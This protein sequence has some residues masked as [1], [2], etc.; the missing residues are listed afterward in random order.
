MADLTEYDR[1]LASAYRFVSYRPRSKKEFVDFCRKT[2]AR[3]HTTAP[4]VIKQ[5][6]DRFA[7]LGY[8]DDK[9]FIEWWV[10]QRSSYRPKGRRAI[11][12]ELQAKGIEKRLVDEYFVSRSEGVDEADLA[13]KAISRKVIIWKGLPQLTQKKKLIDFLSRRGF[14]MDTIYRVVDDVIQKE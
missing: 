5:V 14:A 9:K 3:H 6:L 12:A 2:L 11:T 7:E 8:I 4:L 10:T 1:L 13:R